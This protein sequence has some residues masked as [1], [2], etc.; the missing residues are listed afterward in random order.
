MKES[1]RIPFLAAKSGSY[2][3]APSYAPSPGAK[4]L[5]LHASRPNTATSTE[6]KARPLTLDKPLPS[7]PVAQIINPSSP[8]KVSRTLIDA[9]V[10]GTPTEQQYPV[11]RPENVVPE[12]VE[13]NE[14]LNQPV[15]P[16]QNQVLELLQPIFPE[17]MDSSDDSPLARRHI[18]RRAIITPGTGFQIES[19][20]RGVSPMPAEPPS[21]SGSGAT[22]LGETRRGELNMNFRFPLTS[23]RCPKRGSSRSFMTRIIDVETASSSS[24]SQFMHHT[25]SAEHLTTVRSVSRS[26]MTVSEE[27]RDVESGTRVKRLSNHSQASASGLG[28][29]LTI[30]EDA[31][32]VILGHQRQTPEVPAVPEVIPNHEVPRERSFSALAGRLSRKRG[33]ASLLARSR[34]GTPRSLSPVAQETSSEEGLTINNEN[35]Q[36][37]AENLSA[38]FPLKE[39]GNVQVP[40]QAVGISNQ[41]Q[42]RDPSGCRMG[43]VSSRILLRISFANHHLARK[44]AASMQTA[45]CPPQG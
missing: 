15:Q 23:S 10:A 29:V 4:R 44:S 14:L 5:G 40:V 31:D 21:T 39:K 45:S 35:T 2:L 9:T 25:S 32:M 34:P 11:L 12:N 27:N 16:G 41:Y 20:R 17:Q 42:E 38:G 13:V 24:E 26:P 1:T 43:Q 37:R 18:R 30:S 22:P 28:M 3:K 6:P 36:V 8:P 19:P 33:H 7:P